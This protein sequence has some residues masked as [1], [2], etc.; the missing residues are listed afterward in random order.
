MPEILNI[1]NIKIPSINNKY[2]YNPK[3]KRLFLN[4]AYRNFKKLVSLYCR[5]YK[6]QGP[7]E[8]SI[9]FSGSVDIDNPIKP[10]LDGLQDAEVITDD[11]EIQRLVVNK[12]PMKRTDENWLIVKAVE[13]FTRTVPT[14]DDRENLEWLVWWSLQEANISVSKGR[15]LLGFKYMEEMRE[16]YNAYDR[17]VT[18]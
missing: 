1:K 12:Y 5:K 7:Y 17:R 16:W 11:R 2:Q 4:D 18:Q 13:E 8:V 6:L 3:I 15:E 9:T 14:K 10:I